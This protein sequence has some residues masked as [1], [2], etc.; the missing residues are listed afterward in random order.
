MNY[1]ILHFYYMKTV[2]V[3]WINCW[4]QFVFSLK[5]LYNLKYL[6]KGF[7]LVNRRRPNSS[8]SKKW[9]QLLWVYP[10]KLEGR[11]GFLH[12]IVVAYVT[13]TGYLYSVLGSTVFI[14]TIASLNRMSRWGEWPVRDST[15]EKKDFMVIFGFI[16]LKSLIELYSL[17][18]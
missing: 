9:H 12:C 17:N 10:S 2:D 1:A 6:I 14:G 11:Q 5:Y 4:V 3:V 15:R 8:V 16:S 18:E 13:F 7:K